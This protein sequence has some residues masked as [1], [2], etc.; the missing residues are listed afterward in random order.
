MSVLVYTTDTD[1]GTISVL[2][3]EAD[4]KYQKFHEIA[5]GNAPRGSVKFTK[6][7]RG[8]VSNTSTNTVSE[9]DALT[10]REVAR[11]Q[12]GSGPRGLAVLASERYMLVSNSGSNTVSVVDLETREELTQVAVGR[13][14]R[15]MALDRD[16]HFAYVAIWG[17]GYIAKL[18]ISGLAGGDISTVREVGRIT[19]GTNVFPYS[20]NIA[21]DG[22][23]ACVACNGVAEMPVLDLT[24]ERVAGRIPVRCEGGR[25]VAFS[26][27]GRYAF[28]TLERDSV[29]AVCDLRE[30]RVVRYLPVS[31]GPRG[32]ASYEPQPDRTILFTVGFSRN[33]VIMPES[34]EFEPH[35]V[36]IVTM[37]G[38]PAT[39]DPEFDQV[40][41]GYGPCSVSLFDTAKAGFT[42]E[43]VDSASRTLGSVTAPVS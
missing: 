37:D 13:D 14:P 33:Q 16:N 35:T 18:D 24:A 11:I 10:Q 17:S 29:A 28:L 42:D 19:L 31:P 12:V 6:D 38:D 30:S 20:L 1:A 8:F 40:R 34:P 4:G 23:T 22:T 21:P 25:A 3:Q 32:I 43:A 27:D 15:H 41:V 26:A 36:T 5:V 39:A 7:G 2:R 9:I